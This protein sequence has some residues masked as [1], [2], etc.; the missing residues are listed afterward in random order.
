MS[1]LRD[2]AGGAGA[3][4]WEARRRLYAAG[5]ARP[6]RVAARVVSIG[7]LTVGGTGKTTLAIHLAER[8]RARGVAVAVVCRRYRPGPGGRG[9]EELLFERALGAG[10]V[11][12]GRSKRVLAAEAAAAG[13]RLVLVDDGFSHWGLERDLD[14]VLLDAQ[15]PWGG[16]RLLP[17]GRLREPRR[18][19]QRAQVVVISR[20]GAGRD[21]GA[22]RREAACLAPAAHLAVGRHAVRGVRGLDGAARAAGGRVR[23]VTATGHPAAVADTAREAGF[24]VASLAAY[25]DHHWFSAAEADR[26]RARARSERAT[27]L[28]T[29]KDAVRWPSAA[30]SPDDA[31]LDVAWEWVEGGDEAERRV[32]G[33]GTP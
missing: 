13:A 23:V 27:L 28:L 10:A 26:E 31:V 18:A 16:G 20:A 8:G 1:A 17:G 15:D 24:D 4:L 2:L 25:R 12:A 19:L 30:A 9:D 11:R 21:V 29:A 3:A 6:Q 33:E 14:V 32:F 5:L 22:L 7:N